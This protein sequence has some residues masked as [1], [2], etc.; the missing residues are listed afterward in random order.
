MRRVSIFVLFMVCAQGGLAN[1]YYVSTSGNDNGDGSPGNPWRTLRAAVSK[2]PAGQ[3]HTIRLSQGTFVESGSFN[4]APGINIEGAGVDQTIIKA[5]SSFYFNPGDPGF[6]LDKFLMTLNSSGFSD[7]NQSL[8]NFTIDGDG[9]RLHGGIYVKNRN[10]I[11]IENVKVKD[12]NFCGIWIWDVKNSTLRQITL[13]N[14][15]WGSTGWASGGL[16][17]ANLESVDISGLNIDENTGYGIKALGSGGNRITRLKVHDSRISVNPVG[18]WNNGSAANIAFELWEV[19]LTD[20][21]IYNTYMDNHLSLVNVQTPPTGGRSIRVHHNVFDLLERAGGHGYAI[22]L[23]I[24]DAEIDNNWIKGG[25]Y[26]IAHWSPAYCANWSIHHNTFHS[27]SSG[28]PG[29]IVRAQVS[30]LHN[31]KFH[32][33]TVELMGNATINVIGL[34]AGKSDNLDLKNN[35]IINSN[36]SYTWFPN[37]LI[38]LEKGASL[39][40]LSVGNNLLDKLPLGSVAGTYTNNLE[41]ACKINQSGNRPDPY[42]LPAGGSPLIDAGVNVGLPFQGAAPDIGAY[43]AKSAAAPINQLPVITITAPANE[44]RFSKGSSVLIT[45]DASD[46]D[47]T[48]S[49]VEFFNGTTKL[50]EDS[51]TP[52][53]FEWKDL[54]DGTHTLTAKATDN[55]GG[56]TT[57]PAVKI[58]V[59]P[60]A[61][62]LPTISIIAPV[63]NEKFS[64]GSSVLITADAT[65]KDGTVSKVEFFNGTTKLGEDATTPFAFEWKDLVEGSHTLTAKA[66]DNDGGSTTSLPVKI[67]VTSPTNALPIVAITSPATGSEFPASSSIAINVNASDADGSVVKVEFFSGIDKLGEDTSSPFSFVWDPPAGAYSLTAKASDNLGGSA[68]STAV[69]IT[70]ITSNAAPVISL[71]TPDEGAVFDRGKPI[72]ISAAASDKDGKIERVEFFTGDTKIGEDTSNPYTLTWNDASEGQHLITAKATDDNGESITSQPVKITVNSAIATEETPVSLNITSP[73]DNALIATGQSIVIITDVNGSASGKVEFFHGS[74]KLGEDTTAPFSFEWSD[75]PEGNITITARLVENHGPIAMDEVTVTVAG[76]PIAN[77][78]E[79]VSLSYPTNSIQLTGNGSS[80][81]GSD[82]G[83]SWEMISGPGE[84]T[85]SDKNSDSPTLSNLVEGTYVIELTVTDKNGMEGT[86]QLQIFVSG[87]D[88]ASN[89][90]PRYFT[91]ND[92]GINDIWEWPDVEQYANSSLTIFNRA[93]QKIYEVESYNNSWDGTSSGKPLQA[94]AYYYVIR[95][96][97][98]DIK[99]AVR[100]IR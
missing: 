27:L 32:N 31:V 29:D 81:D 49:K 7:G 90:I 70:V 93:G 51:T 36:T 42:Y 2:V 1:I 58:E 14:C 98:G 10:N 44:G 40:G 22:E 82:V 87:S 96:N 3:G 86:D 4:V 5:A 30:G 74:L 41:T 61:N 11:A 54:A 95:S 78:G 76:N 66:T 50:G 92:D 45:A 56:S 99:G 37:Q 19:Y 13:I 23:S 60:A 77:A 48:V 94:D 46:K 21:E 20:C 9:K 35:L 72:T 6:A 59:A 62:E 100:I 85:F 89:T 57:S 52:F 80:A 55:A 15:S 39:S 63:N 64:K 8:K 43:E 88:V 34:H 79:D 67:E 75:A 18:K 91:P 73:H 68:T 84:T 69:A 24:N 83:F 65:D 47:G 12:T 33:N 97:G 53:A 38:F 25:S 71:T 26:G 16:Q 28:Y 17:L